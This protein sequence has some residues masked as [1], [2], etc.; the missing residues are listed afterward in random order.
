[1]VWTGMVWTGN[2][3]TGAGACG[4]CAAAAT[5]A[6]S[7]I[8]RMRM[9][10]RVSVPR[11]V[12]DFPGANTASRL[13][14]A[15]GGDPYGQAVHRLRVDVRAETGRHPRAGLQERRE[16][17]S[18]VAEPPAAHAQLPGRGRGHRQAGR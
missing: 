15:D 13:D 8:T 5:A 14:R 7:T 6:S 4:A 18:L 10:K 11:V 2:A 17:R 9:P 16:G 3:R 12:R 1:M